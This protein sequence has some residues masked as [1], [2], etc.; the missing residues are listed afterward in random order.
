MKREKERERIVVFGFKDSLV[1]QV[2][3]LMKR[4]SNYQKY[5]IEYFISLS[6]LPILDINVEKK[7][8]P[9]TKTEFIID[10]KIFCKTVFVTEN[11]IEL[12]KKDEI[13]SVLVL[14]DNKDL[15]QQ[16]FSEIKKNNIKILS[17]IHPSVFLGGFNTL[18]EGVIIFPNCYIGYKSDI[19]RGTILQSNCVI[20]HHNSI[21]SFTDVN[22]NVTT[23]GFTKIGDF[24]EINMSV[25]IINHITI[26]N[27]C[28]VGAGSLVLKDCESDVL[29]YGRPAKAMKKL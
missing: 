27:R 16:I 6:Q 9:N 21:G 23:G 20:E 11:Y 1:G 14:E 7:K 5:R 22:P 12:L 29:Y 28:R 13:S 8:R 26:H 15:R 19:G 2:I 24:V 17:F 10:G 4:S 3:E 18:G 25:D